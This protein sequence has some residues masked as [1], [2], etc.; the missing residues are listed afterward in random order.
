MKTFPGRGWEQGSGQKQKTK[1]TFPDK[2]EVRENS[3]L[4]TDLPS[5]KY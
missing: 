2:Q 3:W 5:M 1:E 4:P